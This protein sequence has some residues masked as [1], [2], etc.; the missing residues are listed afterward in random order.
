MAL[1]NCYLSPIIFNSK[2]FRI[3]TNIINDIINDTKSIDAANDF[4]NEL[5]EPNKIIIDYD[6]KIFIKSIIIHYSHNFIRK[7]G[8]YV[9]I[10]N[11]YLQTYEIYK[12]LYPHSWLQKEYLIIND[13]MGKIIKKCNKIKF[14]PNMSKYIILN[15]IYL[16]GC[17]YDQCIRYEDMI[18][19]IK[20]T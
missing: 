17:H 8:N 9:D 16:F 11:S 20:H 12:Q 7:Y 14:R 13:V 4:V 2:I 6:T 10:F 3:E 5:I 19:R 1:L 18:N 15:N